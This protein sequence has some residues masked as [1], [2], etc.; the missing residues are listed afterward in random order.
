MKCIR[1]VKIVILIILCVLGTITPPQKNISNEQIF[2]PLFPTHGKP[3]IVE[4]M[5]KN[6]KA[7][8]LF[9]C[10]IS[11]ILVICL[12]CLFNPKTQDGILERYAT[13]KR[14]K[15]PVY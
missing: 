13:M 15:D 11:L 14:E 7:H 9:C 4:A 8:Y 10:K 12:A 1:S 3:G 2:H 6:N 5:G